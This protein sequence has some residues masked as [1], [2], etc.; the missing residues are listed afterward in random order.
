MCRGGFFYRIKVTRKKGIMM[1]DINDKAFNP[2]T[3]AS[4]LRQVRQ[5][6]AN[7]FNQ[8]TDED[9]DRPVK[10]GPQEW[11]LR[12]TVAHLCALNGDGLQSI[13]SIL[14]G[15]Q[16]EFEGLDNRYQ[17]N[18]YNLQGIDRYISLSP[19]ELS[20]KILSILE[21]AASVSESLSFSQAEATSDM[22]IYNRPVKA[23]EG[24]SIIMFHTGLHHSAQVAEPANFPPLWNHLSPDILHRVV[25]RVMRALSLLYRY[26]LG[27][28]LRATIAFQIDG[29]GGGNWFV[30]VSPEGCSSGFGEINKPTLTIH[31]KNTDVFCKMF[32]SRL[33][34]PLALIT[35][36][37]KLR[38]DI[39][40]FRKFKTLFKVDAKNKH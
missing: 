18:A 16:F 17:F 1:N 24:L 5:I 27:G 37:M 20:A 11:N 21:Q 22:P 34:L 32:T 19:E 33:N 28:D 25:G 9:W 31:M 40:L 39:L 29:P 10:D 15:N 36:K 7:F 8:L 6:Y 26:D 38:G 14:K 4:D 12:Q 23:I 35:G 13:R 3:L 2:P 30:N